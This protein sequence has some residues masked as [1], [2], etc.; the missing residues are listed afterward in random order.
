MRWNRIVSWVVGA[1]VAII[2]PGLAH[3]VPAFARQTGQACEAC[4]VS[5]P[6]L[7]PYGR[8]F[9]LSGYTLGTTQLFP[10]SAMAIGSATKVNNT[11]G[12]D[13]AFPRNGGLVFE[14]GSLFVAGKL[15]D[16]FGLFSQWTY[17]DLF[18]KPQPDGTTQFVGHTTVDNNDIRVV[19]HIAKQDLDLI[20][21]LTLNNNPTVQDVWN[22]TPAFSYPFQTSRI[23]GVWGIAPPAT[24]IEGGLAQQ[25]VGLSAY[26][27]LNK[28]WYFELG[29]YRSAD[30]AFS[31]LH[32]G[33]DFSNRLKDTNPYWRFAYNR[34][35]G[36]H[37]LSAGTFGLNAKVNV[38]PTDSSSPTDH[39][40]DI[41]IDMQYQ[42]LSEPH[43]AT[44]QVSLIHE[45]TDWD[46]S[47]L[48]VDRQNSSSNLDSFHLKGSYWYQRK[49]GATL[50]YFDEYGSDDNVAFP[51]T[52]SPDTRGFIAELNYMIRPFWRLAL[53]YTGYWK[54]LGATTNFDGNGRNARDNNT[55]YLYTW[56][57]F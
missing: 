46:A 15:S 37:S 14:G 22:S 50:A 10:L 56:V 4:H 20:Y 28:S 48:G 6:E 24:L 18:A 31:V 12:N 21:G 54:Y 17:N 47:H 36:S 45:S 34:E 41:G 40:R 9:K 27:F 42:Y 43:S 49:Y 19:D 8:L 2:L 39:F 16:H 3:A 44:A 7:T 51:V 25:V 13:A 23:A 29:G 5:F 55:T 11:Q 1:F 35:W 26:A 57:A 33:V 53:Q 52:N 30:G 38:D 32:H